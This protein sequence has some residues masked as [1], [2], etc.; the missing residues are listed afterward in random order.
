MQILYILQASS[1]ARYW[2]RINNMEDLGA[3]SYVYAFE[4]EKFYK[5]KKDTK[6]YISLG[7]IKQEKYIKRLLPLIKSIKLIRKEIKNVDVIYAFGLDTFLIGWVASLLKRNKP[8]FVYE[9]GDIRSV[10]TNEGLK[11]RL[12]RFV[13]R[14]VLKKMDLLVVTSEAYVH[15]YFI[16]IQKY[17]K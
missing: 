10:F 4:R 7:S 3:H 17:H 11:A 5:G 6:H 12:F 2:R 1:H 16:N 9:V 13:E 15:G 8:K 14:F